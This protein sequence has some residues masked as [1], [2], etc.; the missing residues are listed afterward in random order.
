MH[1]SFLYLLGNY[2]KIVKN[3]EGNSTVILVALD[4]DAVCGLIILEG[5]L[6]RDNVQYEVIPVGGF[7]DLDTVLDKLE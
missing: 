6:R 3:G 4:V 7:Q 1:F 5:L 2:Q